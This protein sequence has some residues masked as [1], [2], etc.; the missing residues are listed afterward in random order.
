MSVT[1]LVRAIRASLERIRFT[2]DLLP[3][4]VTEALACLPTS[5]DFVSKRGPIF[6]NIAPADET[7]QE[8]TYRS[9]EAQV[10]WFMLKLTVTYSSK[11][12]E[13]EILERVMRGS[14][15][16]MAILVESS[17]TEGW[18]ATLVGSFP[19]RD[20]LRWAAS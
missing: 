14:P 8:G 13:L 16:V 17:T 2:P 9:P 18:L 6:A 20:R 3:A 5:G 19:R 10:D 4:D 12:E 7:D 11:K 1:N 15:E